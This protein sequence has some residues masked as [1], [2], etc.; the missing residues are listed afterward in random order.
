ME[1]VLLAQRF[2]IALVIPWFG[3][4]LK[5]GAEQQAWQ[6]A[7]RLAQAGCAVDV[8]TTCCQ[9]FL[10]DWGQNHY[11]EGASQSGDL[12]LRRFRVGA[13]D[14]H[15]FNRVVGKML[16][17]PKESLVP[18]VYPLSREEEDIYWSHNIHSPSMLDYVDSHSE[19]YDYFILLPYLFAPVQQ[20]VELVP[21]K[22]LLQP[23]L[24]DEVYAY[25][26]RTY[27][28]LFQCRGLLFNSR[29]EYQLA[30][31]IYGDWLEEKSTIVGEG[32]EFDA[33][34]AQNA[35][36]PLVEGDY[37]LSLGRRCVEKNTP[38]V[39]EGFCDFLKQDS[40]RDLKLVLAGPGD[41]AVPKDSR[42]VDLGLVDEEQ[43]YN[44]LANCK[45]LA[46][47]STN[48]S[49][50]RVIF[51]A[52]RFKKPVV[53][54]AECEATYSAL[55][56]AQDAGYA[57]QSKD[58]WVKV[59][60]Q[61]EEA[62]GVALAGLGER[63]FAFSAEIS[64][65]D[66]VVCRYLEFFAKMRLVK[67]G[68]VLFVYPHKTR[69]RHEEADLQE[70]MRALQLLGFEVLCVANCDELAVECLPDVDAVA[71]LA[72]D[73][74]LYQG[75]APWLELERV[76]PKAPKALRVLD[77]AEL[78]NLHLGEDFAALL[79]AEDVV[80]PGKVVHVAQ[81]LRALV[82]LA[83][84][85]VSP[86]N[87]LSDGPQI[88]VVGNQEANVKLLA[89]LKEQFAVR[90]GTSLNWLCSGNLACDAVLLL[91]DDAQ[92][93]EI[94]MKA[95]ILGIAT[96]LVASQTHAR[97]LGIP[98]LRKQDVASIVAYLKLALDEAAFRDGVLATLRQKSIAKLPGR[99]Q[100]GYSKAIIDL[101]WGIREGSP[102]TDKT[103]L[104]R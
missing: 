71:D 51:E 43:K 21:R 40:K 68:Q 15:A 4:D 23:C 74:V 69:L 93:M 13:R 53:V 75:W 1:T 65:W 35:G 24:H 81:S 101:S 33:N 85:D 10:H 12:T 3:P 2:K 16:A 99:L 103:P 22:A 11:A 88:L 34:K 54:H 6:I 56:D 76:L 60:G 91:D 67:R 90:Y 19:Q 95:Q 59:L 100:Q 98:S 83:L 96:C 18:G 30:K 17:L 62:D 72:V 94:A 45:A 78:A 63:G 41:Y 66:R 26:A 92:A 7:Q 77:V 32:I 57:V 28:T 79:V 39:V 5:G 52:W 27:D 102:Q 80:Y 37:V 86:A 46:N 14:K 29:G 97:Q 9:S 89:D 64:S 8:L 73:L 49:F 104:F 47:L 42:I 70:G 25:L 50:S 55:L 58:S 36:A 38:L 20:I 61:L 48:E 87:N 44:L 31:R 82:P 84:A